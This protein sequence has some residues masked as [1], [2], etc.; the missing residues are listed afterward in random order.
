M[1]IERQELAQ[2]TPAAGR[3]RTRFE[4]YLGSA[5][6]A[7]AVGALGLGTELIV[8]PIYEQLVRGIIGIGALRRDQF[9]FFE[10]HCLVDDQHQKDLLGIAAEL[11][12]A[13]NG[14][15]ELRSGMRTALRLRLEF[16][17][18]LYRNI[19][20]NQLANPA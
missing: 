1:G 15:N 13:P 16:W 4:S 17:D 10:L 11:A 9:V 12:Q 5:S 18:D 19:L 7:Q 14:L 2:P 8:R 3:W 6:G 20:N